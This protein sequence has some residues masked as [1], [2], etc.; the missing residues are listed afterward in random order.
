MFIFKGEFEL[1]L[2]Y[3]LAALNMKKRLHKDADH[4]SIYESL[5]NVAVAYSHL[6]DEANL[7]K[8]QTEAL[9]MKNRLLNREVYIIQIK[10]V[11]TVLK[12]PLKSRHFTFFFH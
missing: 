10:T 5:W 9:E 11:H 2:K 1:E 8:Y 3:Q 6:K 4:P 7:T 12:R